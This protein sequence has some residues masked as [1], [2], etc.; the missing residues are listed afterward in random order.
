MPTD[1]TGDTKAENGTVRLCSR[2]LLDLGEQ[3]LSRGGSVRVEVTG[4]SMRPAI[5]SGDIVVGE[6]LLE[7]TA[8]PGE[9]VALRTEAGQPVVHRVVARRRRAG[10]WLLVTTGDAAGGLD[11]IVPESDALARVVATERDGNLIPVGRRLPGLTKRLRAWW[12][13]LLHGRV[14]PRHP[15]RTVPSVLLQAARRVRQ[16]LR[17][18]EPASATDPAARTEAARVVQDLVPDVRSVRKWRH[19]TTHI[20]RLR[21]GWRCIGVAHLSRGYRRELG[22]GTWWITDL[23]THCL[24]RGLGVGRKVVEGCVDAARRHGIAEV[25]TAVNE[26]NAASLSLFTSAGFR[27]TEDRELE[28]AISRVHKRLLL[29]APRLVVLS[30]KTG[31]PPAQADRPC[32]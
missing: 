8:E 4:T 15:L 29:R 30:R 14:G 24:W 17:R 28:Q 31:A 2:D 23:Y 7:G 20:V 5:K 21:R 18:A 1:E 32:P 22:L 10:R 26:G 11:S 13:L 27:R 3:L 6:P 9:V 25:S 19:G 12:Q 16:A